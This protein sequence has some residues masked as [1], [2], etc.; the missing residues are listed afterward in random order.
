MADFEIKGIEEGWL[1]TPI[2]RA[3]RLWCQSN[4]AHELRKSGDGYVVEEQFMLQIIEE[5][6]ERKT[7]WFG[8]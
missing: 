1:L 7:G 8:Y 3:S 2:T 6:M 4:L 5:F